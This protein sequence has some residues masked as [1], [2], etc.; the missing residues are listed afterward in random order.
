MAPALREKYFTR[1]GDRF[2]FDKDLRRSVIFGRHDLIQDAPISRV[3]LLTCRNTLM[4]FNLEAQNR[5]LARFHFAL[6]EHGYLFL[7]KAEMLLAHSQLRAAIQ[8]ASDDRHPVALKDMEWPSPGRESRYFD[9][10]VTPL[11]DAPGRP[12]ALSIALTDVT[13]VQELAAK[14]HRSKQ[15]LDT[16]YE[17]LQST[18]EELETT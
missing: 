13:R 1:D 15:D 17:E 7:G 16:A 9:V 14:L 18:N 3:S 6:A 10:H 5:I 8:R 12:P 11:A 2:V 4:Y